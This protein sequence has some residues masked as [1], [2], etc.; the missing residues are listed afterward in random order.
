MDAPAEAPTRERLLHFLYEAAELEHN[1]MCTYLYAA[2]SLR[3]GTAEGLS[4]TEADAVARWRRTIIDVAIDEMSHLTAIWNITSAVGGVPRVGRTNFPLDPGW[5]PARVIVRLEPFSEAVLQHFIHLERSS[6]S[7]EPDGEGFAPERNFRRSTPWIKLVPLPLDYDTVGEF[8][9]NL[10]DGLCAMSARLGEPGVF[11]GDPALQLSATEVNLPGARRV[12][13]IKTAILALESIV[14]Q[15]EGAPEDSEN[16]H[17][18]RFSALRAEYRALKAQNPAFNPAHPAATNP[19]LREPPRPGGRV[20]LE[21]PAAIATVDLANAAYELMVRLLAYAYV[22]PAPHPDKSLA[23]DLSMGLMQAVTALG[24]RAARLPAGSSHP[25]SN[26]GMSFTTLRDT[27]PLPFGPGGRR[28]FVERM[29]ELSGLAA[30]LQGADERTRKCARIMAALASTARQRF[31]LSATVAPTV[32]SPTV[33]AAPTAPGAER[34]TR[35][36]GVQYVEGKAMTLM[37]EGK[38][39][40][41]SR[42]CVTGAPDVFL[43]NVKGNWMHPDAMDAEHVVA[44]AHACPSGAIRYKRKDGRPDESAPLVNLASVREAGP[45]AVRGKL[46]LDGV[47]AG[48]RA[49]LCRCGASGNKPFCDSSHKHIGFSATGEPPSGNTDTLPVRNGVLAIDPQVNG[50]LKVR[51]NLEIISGTGRVVARVTNTLLCRCGASANKPFCDNSHLRIG[52][53]S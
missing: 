14:L 46:V 41:H 20:W 19:V 43:S 10:G 26:A 22:V 48:Y 42:F 7:N 49:T 33:A 3:S 52:F 37:F 15:G 40:I 47:D 9:R 1:L 2:F 6:T 39:C 53:T 17:F 27:A 12:T 35:S 13:C 21:D 38:L 16:S 25:D 36:G 44:V 5:L 30:S 4:P 18:A 31:D 29:D 23:V 28:F 45:Y 11:I 34:V 24:E 50:P 32:A 8:Y 51:G